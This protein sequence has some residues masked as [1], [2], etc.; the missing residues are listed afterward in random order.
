MY[1]NTDFRIASKEGNS[2]F[3]VRYCDSKDPNGP[4]QEGIAWPLQNEMLFLF[5]RLLWKTFFLF[6]LLLCLHSQPLYAP[7]LRIEISK[8]LSEYLNNSYSW[9][10]MG[11]YIKKILL[12]KE[13]EC[14]ILDTTKQER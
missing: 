11:L 9:L 7:F 13:K 1:T 12:K 5:Q 10:N 2:Y 6:S 3:T 8:W 14:E 4:S